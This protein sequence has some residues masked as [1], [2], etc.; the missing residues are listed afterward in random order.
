MNEDYA[1]TSFA[2]VTSVSDTAFGVSMQ[3]Q[4]NGNDSSATYVA[5]IFA[6]DDQSFGTNSDEAI[7][8][9]G[10]TPSLSLNGTSLDIDLG[11][12]PQFLLIKSVDQSERWLLLDNMRGLPADT[13]FNAKQIRA[14]SSA[15]ETSAFRSAEITSTGFRVT[16][17]SGGTSRYIYMA[18]RRPHKPATA[19]TEVFD[20]GLRSG[21]SSDAKTN[22]SIL[23]D[24]SF[25]LRRDSSSEYNG[26]TSR[27]MGDHTLMLNNNT[28]GTTGW[29]DSSKSWATMTGAIVNG[30]NGAANTGNLVDY[31][32]KRAPG[33]FDVVAYRGNS[34][35]NHQVS[36]NLGVVPEFALFKNRDTA[37]GWVEFNDMNASTYTYGFFNGGDRGTQSYGSGYRMFA[38][39][40]ATTL[41]LTDYAPMNQNSED[42]IVYLFASLSGISKVGSYS[43]TGSNINVDCGF[44]A[45]A[46]FILI[47]RTDSTGDWYVWDTL[48]GIVSGNDPYLLL[49][50]TDS[51]VTNTDYIDPLNAG[52]TVTSSAPAALNASGGTYLFL[53]IA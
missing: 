28:T 14:D 41:F 33:F 6:H 42:Y 1:S 11:F 40:S 18:I 45:G 31:S 46:R 12:E 43:G 22:S 53:A 8:K 34:A 21:S 15:A 16:N 27:L 47:K 49:N 24:M 32:F 30:G 39:P 36:H 44:T 20:V 19:A 25:I 4:T 5:Y 51:E 29:L 50:E 17:F 2:Y 9:C 26:I 37:D 35:D 13:S 23:T 52:F 10:V 3:F 38:Q 7:I 48:R